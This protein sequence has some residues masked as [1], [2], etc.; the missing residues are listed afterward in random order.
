[1]FSVLDSL[2]RFG[3][4]KLCNIKYWQQNLHQLILFSETLKGN[5]TEFKPL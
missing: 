1:M 2:I 4:E 3:N 5:M